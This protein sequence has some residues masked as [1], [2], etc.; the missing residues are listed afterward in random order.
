M[1]ETCQESAANRSD[2]AHRKVKAYEL[3]QDGWD[4]SCHPEG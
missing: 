2:N 3:T 4:D 1:G